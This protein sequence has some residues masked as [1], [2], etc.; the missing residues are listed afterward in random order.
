MKLKGIL[1]S[2]LFLTYNVHAASYVNTD[3]VGEDFI[4]RKLQVV[5]SLHGIQDNVY[6]AGLFGVWADKEDE[7]ARFFLEKALENIIEEGSQVLGIVGLQKSKESEK[8]EEGQED[9]EK[10][11]NI[12]KMR[13]YIKNRV[14][15]FDIEPYKDAL[16]K[17]VRTK[18]EAEKMG[19][20]LAKLGPFLESL[21]DE[22]RVVFGEGI[23]AIKS[24][25]AILFALRKSVQ[26][27]Y[28]GE[29]DFLDEEDQEY[30][31]RMLKGLLLV[32][33]R[34]SKVSENIV[35]EL[36]DIHQDVIS[37][38]LAESGVN[39]FLKTKKGEGSCG[40][41]ID[42]K[43][44]IHDASA[45]K[46]VD[47]IDVDIPGNGQDFGDKTEILEE[48]HLVI[49]DDPIDRAYESVKEDNN[50]QPKTPGSGILERFFGSKEKEKKD[51]KSKTVSRLENLRKTLSNPLI[52]GGES[53]E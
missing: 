53:E 14:D 8:E 47:D 48:S 38:D 32:D 17:G 24:D 25:I 21:K 16:R 7:G 36:L 39:S 30:K 10:I 49:A 44:F 29:V 51:D 37:W 26:G 5:G 15:D 35:K 12:Q 46:D 22:K 3:H 20:V 18:E 40:M 42:I 50:K 23:V 52:G 2:M 13:E 34:D 41:C 19:V 31:S 28:L 11:G 27:R 43:Q 33:G 6:A 45:Q 1:W 4:T 9:Q